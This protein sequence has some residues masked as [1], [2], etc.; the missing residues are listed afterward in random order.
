MI[1]EP[2]CSGSGAIARCAHILDEL[3]GRIAPRF[4]RA[5]VRERERRYLAGLLDRVERKNG[6]Q[7]AEAIGEC[8]A[9]GV[10]RLLNAATW[11]VDA[12]CDDLR[13]YIEEHLG[14]EASGVLIVDETGFPKKGTKSCGVARQYTGT[15]GDTF[16][17]HTT[18]RVPGRLPR[19]CIRQGRRLHRPRALSAA[20][21]DA[22]CGA[23]GGGGH[24][25]GDAVRE[26]DRPG[27]ADAGAGLRRGYPGALGGR[28]FLPRPLG[29]VPSALRWGRCCAAGGFEP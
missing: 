25:G 24:P 26:Q 20:R 9:K 11:D 13:E 6:W 14:D 19:L 23:P 21:V 15:A 12:V 2:V 5:E 22:G 1:A 16:N 18:Q 3:H 10:Q 28:G 17:C 27:R 4:A 29:R 7:L 8:G